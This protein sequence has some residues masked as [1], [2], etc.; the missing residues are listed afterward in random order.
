MRSLDAPEK[1]LGEIWGYRFRNIP[2]NGSS[3]RQGPEITEQANLGREDLS[4]SFHIGSK[5]WG[6]YSSKVGHIF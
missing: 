6:L 1:N 4:H 2:I 5:I 3:H